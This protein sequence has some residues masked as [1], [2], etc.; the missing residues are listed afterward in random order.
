MRELIASIFRF[1]WAMSLTG[2]QQLSEIFLPRDAGQPR[3]S[4]AV[5]L[6]ATPSVPPGQAPTPP[7]ST[8]PTLS[9]ASPSYPLAAQNPAEVLNSSPAVST[10]SPIVNKPSPIINKG[11]LNTSQVVVLGEGLAA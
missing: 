3:A 8:P 1:S 5:P 11:S 6:L 9:P 10:Q 2:L 4:T 7:L